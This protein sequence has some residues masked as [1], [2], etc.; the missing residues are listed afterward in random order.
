MII[1]VII[2]SCT[3]NIHNIHRR[4]VFREYINI[5]V[6]LGIFPSDIIFLRNNLEFLET[7]CELYSRFFWT[8]MAGFTV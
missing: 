5:Y 1:N 8:L 6:L 4:M 2:I 7:L 3:T